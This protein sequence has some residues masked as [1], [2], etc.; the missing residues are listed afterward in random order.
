[1]AVAMAGSDKK[2]LDTVLIKMKRVSS[3]CDYFVIASGSSTTQVRAIADH[4]SRKLRENGERLRHIEGEREASWILMDFGDVVA[5]VFLEE[6]RRFYDLE[7][8]W[9][10]APIER[11][12]EKPKA[13]RKRAPRAAAS[14]KRRAAKKKR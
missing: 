6:T 5:H 4:I 11:F 7:R 8:L 3:V 13:A 1:M 2:A 9:G 12:E 14:G 10:D